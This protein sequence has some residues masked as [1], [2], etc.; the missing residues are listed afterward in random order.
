MLIH[1]A[2]VRVPQWGEGAGGGWFRLERGKNTLQIESGICAW[3]VPAAA[4]VERVLEQ[5]DT[6]IA[7]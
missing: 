7:V 1:C 6:S 5:Y 2:K 3:A 4:D